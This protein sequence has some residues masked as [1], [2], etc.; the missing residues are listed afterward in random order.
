L[1]LKQAGKRKSQKLI[2]KEKLA[3]RSSGWMLQSV[4]LSY[5]LGKRNGLSRFE[6]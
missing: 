5:Q 6:Q 1:K 4:D 3:N 2:G